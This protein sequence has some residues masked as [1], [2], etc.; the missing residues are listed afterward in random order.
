[1]DYCRGFDVVATPCT[2][3]MLFKMFIV[4]A[5]IW[6]DAVSSRASAT[7]GHGCAFAIHLMIPLAS[8]DH[9]EPLS[10]YMLFGRVKA[11]VSTLLLRCGPEKADVCFYKCL[12]CKP[13][14]SAT[15]GHKENGYM[16]YTAAFH[17]LLALLSLR[18][19]SR[20][21]CTLNSDS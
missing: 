16:N 2:W 13:K 1:M 8:F 18:L 15:C 5:L 6:T 17:M 12:S 9:T 7:S 19:V 3:Q 11:A 4:L 20:R 10:V 14:P 21:D